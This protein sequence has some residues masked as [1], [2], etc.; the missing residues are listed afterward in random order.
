M[1]GMIWHANDILTKVVSDKTSGIPQHVVANCH[2][3]AIVSVVEV[4][5]I[6]SGSRGAGIIMAKDPAVPGLKWSPPCACSLSGIGFG[7]LVG[8]NHKDLVIFIMDT[9]T[10]AEFMTDKGFICDAENTIALGNMSRGGTLNL[11]PMNNGCI[12]VSY[13][14]GVYAGVS[15]NGA[16]FRPNGKANN[17]F[18][19]GPVLSQKILEGVAVK[20]PEGKLTVIDEVYKKLAII[21]SGGTAEP[22][23]AE[24]AKVAEAAAVAISAHES[25]KDEFEIVEVDA[26]AEAAA[27]N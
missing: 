18:Y 13:T 27:G 4:G 3:V 10:L 15:I 25:I 14:N 16:Q 11:D 19:G 12:V 5:A 9:V 26:K 20:M 21:E 22:D 23:A 8:G 1:E 7:L 2:G 6:F 17:A 24:T